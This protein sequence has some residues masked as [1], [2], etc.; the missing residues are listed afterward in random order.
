M[1][2]WMK[3]GV[4]FAALAALLSACGGGN[5]AGGDSGSGAGGGRGSEPEAGKTAAESEKL[6]EPVTINFFYNGYSGS[7][8]DEWKAKIKEKYNIILNPYM[9]ETIENLIASGVK[10]D[11]IAYSAGGLF[12]ALDLQLT[13]DLTDL[14]KKNNFD[15]NRLA[16]GV[17]ES[18]RLYSDKNEIPV[19]P[20]E[21]NNNVVIYNKSIFE[22]FGVPY[23]Q[24]G[25]TWEQMYDVI[26]KV[27]RVEGGVQYRGYSHSGLNLIYKNQLGLPFVD[28]TTNKAK[29]STDEWKHW[30][31]VMTGYY[32]IPNN[33]LVN[34]KEDDLFFKEQTLAMRG[35]PS[36]L[37]L[38]PAA[39]EK[40]LSW[41]AISNPRFAGHEN[42]GSQMNA[43]FLAIP[44]NSPHREEAFKVIMYF[45][46][47]EMQAENARS[48]RVPVLKTD[49]VVKEFGTKLPFLQGSNYAKAVF[50]DT[51]GKPIRVTKY[52]GSVRSALSS[53]IV[54]VATGKADVNTA[55]RDAEETANKAIEAAQKK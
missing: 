17:L 32:G 55:L 46:S 19:M 50:A 16:P 29:I 26:K 37:D 54:N 9:N 24:D 34:A 11:L 10:L 21:L 15:M 20:Y 35:G 39:I 12:K 52:D 41:D 42:E 4:A 53:A 40:G 1:K 49:S 51:I 25:M 33:D 14:I 3:K 36:P 43:P 48:G 18:V 45:L 23:P 30:L 8:M 47:D 2:G 13:S 44:P 31:G 6:K 28:P 27:S 5:G 38:L 7:L 22:K